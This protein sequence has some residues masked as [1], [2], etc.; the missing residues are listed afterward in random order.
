MAYG[1]ITLVHMPRVVLSVAL[2]PGY[3]HLGDFYTLK[4]TLRSVIDL[5]ARMPRGRTVDVIEGWL[6]RHDAV[7]RP[8][9]GAPARRWQ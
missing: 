6:R 5:Q 4:G 3:H 2:A 1:A 7:L 8:L 9:V